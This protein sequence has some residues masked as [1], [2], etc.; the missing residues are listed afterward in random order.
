MSRQSANHADFLYVRAVLAAR[1]PLA[2]AALTTGV[3]GLVLQAL[4]MA[5]ATTP[6]SLNAAMHPVTSIAVIAFAL[7]LVSMG[8]LTQLRDWH[9]AV[10]LGLVALCGARIVLGPLPALVPLPIAGQ[11]SLQ[12]ATILGLQAAFVL[13]RSRAPVV[14]DFLAG[15]AGFILFNA[16]V[17]I[18]YRL[19]LFDGHLSLPTLL[20]LSCTMGAAVVLSVRHPGPRALLRAGAVGKTLRAVS[21]GVLVSSWG[22]GQLLLHFLAQGHQAQ[23]MAVWLITVVVTV[24]LSLVLFTGV[25]YDQAE[26]AQARTQR[27]LLDMAYTDPLTGISNRRA[28]MAGLARMWQAGGPDTP[29]A[30]AVLDVDHFKRINDIHGHAKGDAV[31]VAVAA[32]LKAEMR[33]GDVLCRWGGEEFLLACCRLTP[34]QARQSA[35][36]LRHRIQEL[37]P[38]L[39]LTQLSASFGLAFRKPEDIAPDLVVRRADAAMYRAKTAGRNRVV[40]QRDVA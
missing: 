38:S 30:V 33:P 2:L 12:S 4:G 5:M 7:V 27:A 21:A 31:L 1:V 22:G 9:R 40:V 26:R 10:L 39:G 25:K 13:L 16:F 35:E 20:A 36:A 17:G 3:L 18:S 34:E 37:G 24:T 6:Q 11:F 8:P 29:F 14:S 15:M 23:Q 32:A 19:S 28:G